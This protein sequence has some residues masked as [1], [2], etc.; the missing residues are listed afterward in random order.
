LDEGQEAFYRLGCSSA[1]L[2]DAMGRAGSGKTQ[3]LSPIAEAL[4]AGHACDEIVVAAVAAK[5]A[6]ETAEEVKANRFGSIESLARQRTKRKNAWR[7]SSRTVVILDEAA[8][9]NSFDMAKLLEI[10]GPAKLI[11]IGDIKQATAIGVAGWYGEEIAKRPP[12]ELEKVY[13]QTDERDRAAL[14][15][16]RA[17]DGH[18]AVSDLD[19]RGR[20][21]IAGPCRGRRVGH[22]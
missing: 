12:V 17:G 22:R 5:R 10:I 19:D 8:L 14:E 15:L 2:V 21:H 20:I 16:L 6:R 4:R 18:A 3:A 9:A 1:R 7:P 13:R 11:M